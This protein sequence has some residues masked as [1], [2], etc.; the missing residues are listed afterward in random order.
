MILYLIIF[1]N[2]ISKLCPFKLIKIIFKISGIKLLKKNRNVE[3]W[4]N[5]MHKVFFKFI[6]I[7]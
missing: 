7:N 3:R 1:N 4:N 2:G 5:R 6:N